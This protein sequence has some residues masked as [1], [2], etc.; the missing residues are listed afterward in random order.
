MENYV[1]KVAKKFKIELGTKIFSPNFSEERLQDEK[2]ALVPKFPYRE[3]VGSLQWIATTTRP[4]V[5]VPVACLAR[6]V[7][8][9]CNNAM[10]NAAKKVMKYLLSTPKVGVS[11]DPSTESEFYNTYSQLLPPGREL[12]LINLFSDAGYANC[13]KTLRSTSGSICYYRSVPIFWR[14]NRQSVRAYSTA[15][16]EFIACSDTI[17]L[18][19]HN[20]FLNFFQPTPEKLVETSHGIAPSL[21]NAVLW[22]DN[23]SAITTAKDS[24]TKPRS[25]H[26]ALRYLRVR[27]SA[28][29][30]IFC[31]THLMKADALSKL[32]CSSSQRHMLLHHVSNQDVEMY[33]SDLECY[34]TGKNVFSLYSAYLG[35]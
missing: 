12:P 20:D 11:Y 24:D 16:S 13:L 19:E 17:I 26:Y 5:A 32:E 3:V 34:L 10:M 30:I 15:E 22:V 7:A 1:N 4:G 9:P 29:R 25:R 33:N 21:D 6:Y 27:D 35:F 28:S 14:S 23:T 2:S 31:P 8:E 18:S